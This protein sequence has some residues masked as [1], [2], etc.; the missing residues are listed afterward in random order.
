MPYIQAKLHDLQIEQAMKRV[1][2][3][4]SLRNYEI[5]D[6]SRAIKKLETR[7]IK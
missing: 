1:M 6:L 4:I 2:L 3:G 7:S 5:H